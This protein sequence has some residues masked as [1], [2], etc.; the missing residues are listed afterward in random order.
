M[1]GMT[2]D[3]ARK[4]RLLLG[5][6]LGLI[7][8]CVVAALVIPA[9]EG[10]DFANFYDTGRRVAAGQL[11]DI[12]DPTSLIAGAEPQGKM[13][14]WGAPA[15]AW[16]YVPLSFLPPDA[17]MIAFKLIA[18]LATTAALVLLY[19]LTREFVEDEPEARARFAV[20]F[21]FL[22]LL[23]QP[24]WTIYRVGGQTTPMALLL[25][26]L[27]M[28]TYVRERYLA[29]AVW[30]V[31]MVLVK[32]AFLVIPV[33]LALVSGR[34]FLVSLVG[35]GAVAALGSIAIF[36]WPIH[37]EFLEILRRGSEKPSP[38]PF[39]SSV[40]IVADAF[41]TIKDSI[42]VRGS[43]GLFPGLLRVCLKLL[44]VGTFMAIMIQSYRESW[45]PARRRLFNFLMAIA[46]CLLISQVVWEHYLALLFIPL[47]FLVAAW[48]RLDRGAHRHI[49]AILA[50][51]VLQNLV[52]V[53]LFRDHFPV[54][55]HLML[56]AVSL[57]K[58]GPLLAFWG[59]L[60]FR[61]SSI[62]LVSRS[63]VQA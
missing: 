31:L 10:W 55:S 22:V 43:G 41:R 6:A 17:A 23:F 27:A 56:L 57:I 37:R 9:G 52:L 53:L 13:A 7:V 33:F 2:A 24:F 15:S 59:F 20:L 42:P 8:V 58:A 21:A 18:V 19:R 60:W 16:L 4:H 26:V 50:L 11:R 51:C 35:V 49:A 45:P 61:R 3:S 54:R 39:N 40:Y 30:L 63:L 1:T 47:A 5:L 12:Y 62:F 36:G 14:F 48:H 46:F 38:W 29:A 25:L 32:P 44:V 28:T 34:R